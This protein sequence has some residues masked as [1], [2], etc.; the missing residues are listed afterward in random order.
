MF[1]GAVA[2]Q[3]AQHVDRVFELQEVMK[4]EAKRV[5]T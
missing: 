3:R 1:E 5:V 2:Q 4:K